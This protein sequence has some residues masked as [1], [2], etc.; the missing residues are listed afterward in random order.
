MALKRSR[1]IALGV[2]A[3]LVLLVA[4]SVV[5]HRRQA[6]IVAVQGEARPRQALESTGT[7]VITEQRTFDPNQ[8][9]ERSKQV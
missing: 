1:K 2:A 8:V 5:W 9:Y 3:G 7:A 4:V 6:G